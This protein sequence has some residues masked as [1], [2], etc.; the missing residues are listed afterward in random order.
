MRV[1]STTISDALSIQLQ[2]LSSQQAQLQNQV[3]TG[4]RITDPSDD[5]AAMARVLSEETQKQQIQQYQSN[6]GVATQIS[7]ATSSSLNSLKTVSDRAGELAVLGTGVNSAQSDQAYAT[8]LNQLIEQ[9]LQTANTT[10]G[11]THLFAGTKTDTPPFT[12][13]RD[14][15][16][17][18][19]AVT[20]TGSATS[21]QMQTGEGSLV[22]PFTSGATNQQIGDF[23]NNLVS[24]RNGL[25]NQDTTA[26]QT[27]QT[28]LQTSED[29]ILNAI[30]G[31]GAVQSQL[32]ADGTQNT[33]RFASLD[34]L[35]SQDAN[36]DLSQTVVKL[37][38]T[39]TAY[40][41]ALQ[42]GAQI[43]QL[44]LLNYLPTTLG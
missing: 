39:Q 40:Q 12:A 44:S 27:A 6:Q 34:Q 22:S 11:S 7:Q 2:T 41:A 42:S 37:Q 20:Y 36:A 43:M 33:A 9:A 35:T 32:E 19:T 1:T 31:A 17:N 21:A 18:I 29:N 3:T 13:T 4:Q 8:E 30:S 15:N 24:L 25:T 23:I 14:A 28:G 10:N 38:Q 26:V 5:P 16:G